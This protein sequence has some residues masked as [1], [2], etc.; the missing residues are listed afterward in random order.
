[1]GTEVLARVKHVPMSAHKVRRVINQVRGMD[2]EEALEMLYFLPHAAARPVAKL[3]RSAV[4][5]AEENFGIPR[6]D[7]YVSRIAADDGPGVMPGKGWRRRF[8]GRG[9]S[10]PIRKRSSHITVILE[11]RA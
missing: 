3:I 7:L 8:G 9:R 1:M 4:A 11:E 2:A 10:R 6:D 5:N